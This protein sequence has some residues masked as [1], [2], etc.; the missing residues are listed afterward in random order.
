MEV[1]YF[2]IGA[3]VVPA[4]NGM[5]NRLGHD[6]ASL[7]DKALG[8]VV[9]TRPSK[10]LVQFPELN[11]SLWLDKDELADVSEQAALGHAEYQKLLPGT[12]S[13]ESFPWVVWIWSLARILP[14]T[15]VLGLEMGT[16]S[17]VW[18]DESFRLVEYYSGDDS[19]PAFY[20]G[21]G[22]SELKLADWHKA[23]ALLG[24]RLLFARF[25]PAGMHK[26]EVAFYFKESSR[27]NG[28]STLRSR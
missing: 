16:L 2:G 28:V 5:L 22:V 12:G 26:L 14:V 10:C 27:R 13:L 8:L 18:S 19:I 17:E 3:L 24:D 1:K 15:H 23:E 21:L 6:V 7:G 11:L 20:V 4:R 25:L 9:E